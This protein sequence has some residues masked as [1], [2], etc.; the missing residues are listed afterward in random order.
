M[1]EQDNVKIELLMD[2]NPKTIAEMSYCNFAPDK[3]MDAL[4]E[5]SETVKSKLEVAIWRKL[6]W[7]QSLPEEIPM[8]FFVGKATDI[9]HYKFEA[10]IELDKINPDK[11]DIIIER[12]IN[13]A[14]REMRKPLLLVIAC[15][16]KF[17]NQSF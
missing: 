4:N 1:V 15:T 10:D 3:L 7:T 9:F 11:L 16:E 13:E 2:N 5:V 12:N 8:I 14:S 17:K 6:Y